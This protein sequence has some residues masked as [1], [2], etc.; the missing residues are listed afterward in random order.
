MPRSALS[1]LMAGSGCGWA[2]VGHAD[3]SPSANQIISK[4]VNPHSRTASSQKFWYYMIISMSLINKVQTNISLPI[5]FLPYRGLALGDWALIVRRNTIRLGLQ[6]QTNLL[7]WSTVPKEC[8]SSFL[9]DVSMPGT[10]PT[11]KNMISSPTGI[12]TWGARKDLVLYPYISVKLCLI[13]IRPFHYHELC[14]AIDFS[15]CSPYLPFIRGISLWGFK[16][17]C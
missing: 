12:W 11:F 10:N 4:V 3:K 13:L 1:W 17:Q 8:V 7:I 9:N 2:I 16:S 14:S 6:T 15:L 5:C